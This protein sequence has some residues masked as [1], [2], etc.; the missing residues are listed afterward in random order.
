VTRIITALDRA[1]RKK[2]ATR[3][4]EQMKTGAAGSVKDDAANSS[5]LVFLTAFLAVRDNELIGK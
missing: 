1:A 4:A 5:N 3:Q 2:R